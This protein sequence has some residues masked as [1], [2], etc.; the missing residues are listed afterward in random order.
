[1]IWEHEWNQMREWE[2]VKEFV[3]ALNLV[4]RLEPREAFFGGRTNAVQLY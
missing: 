3:N 4:S 1:M 2:E